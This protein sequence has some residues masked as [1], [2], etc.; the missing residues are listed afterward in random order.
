MLPGMSN[1]GKPSGLRG[2]TNAAEPVCSA[3]QKSAIFVIPQLSRGFQRAFY[4][5]P[6][7]LWKTLWTMAA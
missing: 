4:Y 7:N 5:Y 6:Q 3:T 2:Q 1:I